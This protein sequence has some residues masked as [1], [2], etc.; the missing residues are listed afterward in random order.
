[1]HCYNFAL[2]FMAPAT[3]SLMVTAVLICF[4]LIQSTSVDDSA[5]ADSTAVSLALNISHNSEADS[6]RMSSVKLN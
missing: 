4:T 3:W 6:V 1:M 2:G 5:L